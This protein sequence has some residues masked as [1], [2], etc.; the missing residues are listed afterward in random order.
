MPVVQKDN[1]PPIKVSREKLAQ[2]AIAPE[3][4]AKAAK[5]IYVT[6]EQEGISRKKSG[7]Q[8]KYY[9]NGKLLKDVDD[10]ERIKKLVI[11]PAWTNVWIATQ[12]NGHLQATGYDDKNRKQYKYHSRWVI[13]RNLTKF[14]HLYDFGKALPGIRKRVY[15]DLAKHGLPQVKVLAAVISI[16]QHTN[17]RIGNHEYEKL[18]GSYGLTTLKDR[19]ADI[20]TSS[21][22]FHF[23]GK[24]GVIHDIKLQS[25]RLAK[26]VQ[27]CK[28]I[29]G[30]ELFQYYDDDGKHHSID[31]G[32]INDYIH[33]ICGDEFTAKDFRTWKGSVHALQALKEAGCCDTDK[34]RKKKIVTAIDH[35]AE[36]LGNSRAICRKYYI[37]PSVIDSYNDNSLDDFFGNKK[38]GRNAKVGLSYDERVLMDILEMKKKIVIEE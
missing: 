18:Y 29:P 22:T 10:L 16:M 24:K 35:V 8:F 38:K 32:M 2:L 23:K 9:K 27:R 13:L 19:H 33:E 36:Q 3:K 4:S 37:H 25:R 14:A 20:N 7:E 12:P 17:I 21:V 11:P 26:I 34:E 28:D 30:K 6:D 1:T 31:S 5:L 15:K